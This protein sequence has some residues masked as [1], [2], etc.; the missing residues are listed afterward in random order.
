VKIFLLIV[1]VLICPPLYAQSYAI[2]DQP[3]ELKFPGKFVWIDLLTTDIYVAAKF[4]KSV[5]GWQSSA[6]GDDYILLSNNG[7]RIAGIVKNKHQ[8]E[9]NESNQWISF[10]STVDI[11]KAHLKLVKAGAK[12]VAGP[13]TIEGRGDIGVYVAPDSAVF[14][15]INSL[16]GDPEEIGAGLND[17]VWTELWSTDTRAAAEFYKLLGYDVVD[18]WKSDNEQDLILATGQVARAG[19]VEGHESQTRSIWLAYILVESVEDTIVRSELAGGK[20]HRLL[21]ESYS[22]GKVALISDPTGGLVALYEYSG[23]KGG[24]ASE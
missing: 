20:T 24:Q 3:T 13:M 8:L 9:D 16:M 5:F 18:N 4:Y 15:T 21:G 23:D 1:W 17:W 19:L 22:A 10:I 11:D 14:G 7:K 6:I 2:T 12:A